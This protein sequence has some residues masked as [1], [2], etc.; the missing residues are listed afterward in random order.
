[1]EIISTSN[2]PKAIGPYSQ[3]IIHHKCVYTSGQIPLNPNSNQLITN[4]F[5]AEVEQV[6]LNLDAVLSAGGSSLKNVVKLTVFITD[7]DKFSELNKILEL[8]FDNILP[9]R[10]VVEVSSLPLGARIEIE[11]IGGR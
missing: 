7:L 5:K 6:I 11:A 9:A 4:D 8:F 10:S 2:A 1:M 3:G